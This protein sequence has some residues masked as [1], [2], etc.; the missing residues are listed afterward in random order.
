MTENILNCVMEIA[1]R[2]IEVGAEI[3]RVED[4]VGRICK[5]YGAKHADIYAT[6]SNIVVSVETAEG[7]VLTQSRRIKKSGTDIES[8]D[9]LNSLVRRMTERCPDAEEVREE[10]EKIKKTPN[11]PAWV[12]IAFY[13]VIAGAFCVFFG[14]RT[15]AEI[16]I[17]LFIGVL[18][19][20]V[21][22]L[23]ERFK[24]NKLLGRFLCSFTACCLGFMFVKMRVI[25]TADNVIIGNI[26]SL[27]P[28]VGLTN[29]LR[30]LFTG[31]SV[32]G[33]LRSI[34]AILLALAIAS[35]YILTVYLFGGAV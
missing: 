16:I 24:V 2:M 1:K 3:H 17:A 25:L 26:M 20:I 11:Y 13:G 8:L 27:I 30:D 4:S 28:G 6:I 33:A 23:N 19:G 12:G 22:K 18:V 5:A 9:R 7:V 21:A 31:D 35:G 14:G 32:T 15:F 34:E 29:S 10:L